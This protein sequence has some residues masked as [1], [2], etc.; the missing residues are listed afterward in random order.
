MTKSDWLS[1]EFETVGGGRDDFW[2]EG[3]QG[4][5]AL[6]SSSGDRVTRTEFWEVF[7]KCFNESFGDCGPTD[8]A[9]S[10]WDYFSITADFSK[11]WDVSPS[12]DIPELPN[13]LVTESLSAE[14]FIQ[15]GGAPDWIQNPNTPI[16]KRCDRDM[17]L[18]LQLS[19]VSEALREMHPGLA[20][21]DFAD[22]GRV[23]LFCCKDHGQFE[24]RHDYY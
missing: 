5:T 8:D 20:E 15:I 7:Q 14:R 3:V 10:A 16:C 17:A 21:V 12:V 22:S 19:S 13:E 4:L 24:I 6:F 18:V 23:Y 9:L 11:A 2:P 1:K